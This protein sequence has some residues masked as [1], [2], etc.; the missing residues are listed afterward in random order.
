MRPAQ[1][2]AL[3]E[4]HFSLTVAWK[5]LNNGCI[6]LN[7]FRSLSYV[8][9]C[10]NWAQSL[11]EGGRD[12]TR[13]L[14]SN[15]KSKCINARDW[16]DLYGFVYGEIITKNT[17]KGKHNLKSYPESLKYNQAVEYPLRTQENGKLNAWE[18]KTLNS[19]R[20]QLSKHSLGAFASFRT[21][22]SCCGAE[23]ANFRFAKALNWKRKPVRRSWNLGELRQRVKHNFSTIERGLA[24]VRLADPFLIQLGVG[25]PPRGG[26]ANIANARLKFNGNFLFLMKSNRFYELQSNCWSGDLTCFKRSRH[27]ISYVTWESNG[28]RALE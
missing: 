20:G 10:E 16:W 5:I 6:W 13:C 11:R 23:R 26:F 15:E 7:L 19:K 28:I 2:V 9:M 18:E 27:W 22:S 24:P 12:F 25:T 14:I 4:H 3:W 1:S 8:C 17:E 21:N